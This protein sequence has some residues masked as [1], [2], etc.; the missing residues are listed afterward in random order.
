M[1][2]AESKFEISNHSCQKGGIST[3]IQ[4]CMCEL[5]RRRSNSSFQTTSLQ[6]LSDILHQ[7]NERNLLQAEISINN[8]PTRALLRKFSG[9][10]I[11]SKCFAEVLIN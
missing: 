9:E 6:V 2:S 3:K 1:S 5:A 11:E 7:R 10:C 8:L 4:H